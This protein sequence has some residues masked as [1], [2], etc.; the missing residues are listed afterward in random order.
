MHCAVQWSNQP[1]IPA[2]YDKISNILQIGMNQQPTGCYMPPKGYKGKQGT[3]TKQEYGLYHPT[4]S[5]SKNRL[6][7]AT[8]QLRQVMHMTRGNEATILIEAIIPPQKI[9]V[10]YT[11][12][13]TLNNPKNRGCT[14]STANI[15]SRQHW[16]RL[17]RQYGGRITVPSKITIYIS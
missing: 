6:E 3:T 7:E 15:V 5:K 11:A 17:L 2:R 16:P 8:W 12:R 1:N 10:Q 4:P 9:L 13:Q 14:L